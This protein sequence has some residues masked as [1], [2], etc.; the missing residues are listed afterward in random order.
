M[1]KKPDCY[2]CVHK[3]EVPGDCHIRCNN[4]KA[5]VVGNETGIKHGWFSWPINF[6]TNWLISC[7]GFSSNPK[8]NIGSDS[9][10]P[11]MELL[12]ILGGRFRE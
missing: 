5:K 10:E 11:L 7:D 8:D 4:L 9:S 12:S 2:K 1:S 6:D 3:R